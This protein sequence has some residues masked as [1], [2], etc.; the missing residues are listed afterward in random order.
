MLRGGGG[1]AY[2]GSLAVNKPNIYVGYGIYI[3]PHFT[4]SLFG[5]TQECKMANQTYRVLLQC[6]FKPEALKC[7]NCTDYWVINDSKN[8]R[9]YGIILVTPEQYKTIQSIQSGLYS[10]NCD[11]NTWKQ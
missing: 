10:Q 2:Q 11:W 8:V 7:T 4:T 5:Y 9:P 1:Q 6:R 3:S